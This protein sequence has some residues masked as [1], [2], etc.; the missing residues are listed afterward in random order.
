MMHKNAHPSDG[1]QISRRHL[2]RSTAV[3]AAAGAVGWSRRAATGGEP[4]AAPT[5]VTHARIKQSIVQW[6]FAD[7]WDIDKMCQVA[8]TLGC[9]SVELVPAADWHVLKKYNLVCALAN[10]HLF[11]QGMNN[12]R[13]QPMCIEMIKQSIDHCADAGFPTVITFT[14][15][16]AET[17]PWADGGIPDLTKRGDS[18]RREIDPDQG[19]K[20]CVEGYKKVVGYAEKKKINLSLEMLNSRDSVEMK[21]HPGYQGDHVDYC[22]E[23][24]RQVGSPRLGLLYDIYHVQIMDGDLIRR[25]NECKEVINHVH[26]AG[27]PGRNELDETQEINYPAVMKALVDIGYQ[28]YVG[29]EFIPTRDPLAGLTEAVKLC[30][31]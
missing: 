11:V 29:Q 15:F 1:N 21:G 20:N 14:G 4:N 5:A 17:G 7:H 18:P 6:C 16:A 2:L 26:T 25:I 27:N 12:P 10:S 3:A 31:V 23:I 8:R 9:P 19:V 13:Y 24:I 28:G 22:M 30:D